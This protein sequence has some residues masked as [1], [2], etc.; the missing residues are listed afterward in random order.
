MDSQAY[1]IRGTRKM[2]KMSGVEV[3]TKLGISPQYYYD[4][5]RGKKNLSA[6]KALQLAKIF[7]VTLEILLGLPHHSDHLLLNNDHD[8][9]GNT[10]ESIL[11]DMDNNL[12]NALSKKEERDIALDLERIMSDLD[13]NEALAFHG[14]PINEETK[15]A[16]RISLESSMKLA[17]QFAKQKYT[18]NKYKK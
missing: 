6:D 16:L 14:E 10:D 8:T 11:D 2:R 17:K 7:D 4:I 13:S 1:R 18:P 9:D 3:A 15:E 5:E 12:Q